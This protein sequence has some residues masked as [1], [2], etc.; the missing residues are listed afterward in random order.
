M[1]KTL[2]LS[3]VVILALFSVAAIKFFT[4]YPNSVPVGSDFFVLQRNQSYINASRDQVKNDWFNNPAFTGNGSISGAFGVGGFETVGGN[5]VIG[6][7]AFGNGAGLTNITSSGTNAS[8][9]YIT[10]TIL[11]S[12]NINSTT[13]TNVTLNSTTNIL[14]YITNITLVTT[15]VT[16]QAPGGFTNEN[17]TPYTFMFADKNDAE[18]SFPNGTGVLTNGGAGNGDV[19]WTMTLKLTEV[20]VSNF[21]PTNL[22]TGLTNIATLGTDANG[23]L[24]VGSSTVTNLTI[25]N[26]YAEIITNNTFVNTNTVII[27]GKATIKTL[28]V[29]NVAIFGNETNENATANTVAYY[30]ANKVIGS[31]ANGTG[32]LTNDGAGAVGWY[33]N[34]ATLDGQNTFSGSNY[35]GG[36][37]AFGQLIRAAAITVTNTFTNGAATA[38]TLAYQDS[39]KR[40]ISVPNAYGVATNDGAGAIGFNSVYP[41]GNGAALTNLTYQYNTNAITTGVLTFGQAYRTNIAADITI[42]SLVLGSTVSYESMVLLVTNSDT[43]AHKITWPSGVFSGGV[44]AVS[45]ITNGYWSEVL[46]DHFATLYTNAV[47]K[48]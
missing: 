36:Q 25:T 14:N 28:I 13:I 34:Y 48:N 9:T 2:T 43:A 39:G 6:G 33:G 24:T 12:T 42:N 37:S 16:I 27:T 23:V 30:D 40:L 41:Q 32:A 4:D 38:S 10:N 19:A 17:L 22:F 20:D 7:I 11:Y 47:T 29:T 31:L 26:L 5:L 18:S 46:V 45:W 3:V 44:A 15:N 21:Y 8:F 1:R 35:F